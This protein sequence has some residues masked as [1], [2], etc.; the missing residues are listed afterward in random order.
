MK[1]TKLGSSAL[2]VSRICLGTMT[3]GMQ[4]TQKDAFQQ[5]E[6]A[7]KHGVNFWD[8]AEMYAIPPTP[9][10]YA[11]TETIIGNWFKEN[12]TKRKDVILATKIS[13][14]PWAR[15]EDTPTINRKTITNA[16]DA[17]LK[18]L[19]SD[20]IDLYQLHWP[21]NKPQY[22]FNN[23]WDFNVNHDH[24]SKQKIIDS[25]IE[26]LQTFQEF[27]SK[28]KIRAIGISNDTAWGVKQY[29]ELAEQNNL[30]RIVSLQNEYSLLRRR[31]EYDV[32]ET[33]ALEN[34]AY[35]AW[36]PLAMGVLSGK[37]LDQQFPAGSRFSKE[38]M[39]N[40]WNRFNSRVA[41]HTLNATKAYLEVAKKHNLDA[42]QMAY[43]FT[44]RYPW[45]TS[46]IIGATTME[47]LKSN[48]ASVNV[49]LSKQCI[50]DI[51]VV[52]QQYPTPF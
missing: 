12:P 36:S 50:D 21:V 27:I 2:N 28:G 31:D 4:N 17:S 34:V 11:T 47:Q 42:C 22:H 48:V 29:V 10:T 43:A 24:T 33:C 49:E 38:I 41:L 13:P 40:Q 23:W 32:A 15:N 39:G 46:T 19:Q 35:L 52:Y 37:Y 18:R 30:P 9:D 26:I 20:Y 44:I 1:Y 51:K 3:W 6:Y 8:T 5:I 25:K 45:L 7:L 14:I 16:L